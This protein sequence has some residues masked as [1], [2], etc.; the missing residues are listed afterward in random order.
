MPTELILPTDDYIKHIEAIGK[1]GASYNSMLKGFQKWLRDNAKIEIGQAT[2]IHVE[3]Y[4]ATIENEGT[5]KGT[6]AAIRG[7]FKYRYSVLS[8][9]DPRVINEMQRYN[10]MQNIKLTRRVRKLEKKSLTIPELKKFLVVLQANGVSKELYAGIVVGFYFGARPVEIASYLATAKISFKD[11]DMHIQTAKTKVER[12]LAW[13]P[14]MDLY[15]KTWYEFIR[16][17]EKDGLLYPGQW[18]TKNMK[19]LLGNK[20]TVGGVPITARTFRR[21]FETQMRLADVPDIAIRAIL[22][23][24]DKSISDVYTDWTQFVPVIKDA[25]IEKHYMIV[26]GVI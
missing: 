15:V 1:S 18:I 20:R 23:H 6:L 3:Q 17:D 14:R 22:G 7:Y 12:Y 4:L 2:V 24:T 16:K 8:M 10:Q 21:V 9:G 5:A 11:R 26:N 13:H 25:M 19:S